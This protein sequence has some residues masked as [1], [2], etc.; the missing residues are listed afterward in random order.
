MSRVAAGVLTA[1]LPHPATAWHGSDAVGIGHAV[2]GTELAAVSERAV[3]SGVDRAGERPALVEPLDRD[4]RPEALPHRR[5]RRPECL[6]PAAGPARRPRRR[7]VRA[8]RRAA[9]GARRGRRGGVAGGERP[10]WLSALSLGGALLLAA[11][12]RLRGRAS[13]GKSARLLHLDT[14]VLVEAVGARQ[15]AGTQGVFLAGAGLASRLWFVTLGI[16]ARALAAIFVRPG[17]LAGAGHRARHDHACA[18]AAPQPG[19]G[20]LT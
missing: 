17:C 12:G 13:C 2:R 6:R 20:T 5:H 19:R 7:G 18:R 15:P 4:L 14:V 16:G 9:D 11:Q 10:R 1:R 8:A 3:A